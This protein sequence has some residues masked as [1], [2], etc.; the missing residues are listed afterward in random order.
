MEPS[1]FFQHQPLQLYLLCCEF[2]LDKL[3][4][5]R[6]RKGCRS[7]KEKKEVWQSRNLQRWTCL[8]MFRQVLHLRK[9]RSHSKKKSQGILIATV[10]PESMMRRNSIS[11]AN[12]EFSSATAR[13]IPWR[14]DGHSHGEPCR[15]KRGIRWSGPLRICNWEWRRCDRE[16][17][18]LTKTAARKPCAASQ[19]SREVEKLKR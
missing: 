9:V 12:V 11:D 1:S 19:T 2:Q 17:R 7:K 13:C 14:I 5:K 6:W 10:K 18:L 16:N 4:Q 3:L 15:N 8:L